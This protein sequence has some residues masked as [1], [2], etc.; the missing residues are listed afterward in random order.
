MEVVSNVVAF[1]NAMENCCLALCLQNTQISI[2]CE[3]WWT[4]GWVDVLETSRKAEFWPE[5]EVQSERAHSALRMCPF[6]SQHLP[7]LSCVTH[8]GEHTPMESFLASEDLFLS[9]H[10]L[11]C[12]L[13]GNI[14]I[15][16]SWLNLLF[17]PFM[18]FAFFF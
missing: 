4:S 10:L 2:C 7:D 9:C 17:V 5:A 16:F 11:L 8:M 1:H 12:L 14:F 18:R 15:V 6:P 3:E 13:W